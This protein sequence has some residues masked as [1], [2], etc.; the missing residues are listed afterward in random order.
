LAATSAL[1]SPSG[2]NDLDA[3]FNS[4][5]AA[6]V[7]EGSL[8]F[9]TSPPVKPLHHHQNTIRLSPDSLT[10]GW[11]AL[12]QCHDNLDAV[13]RAQITFR[14]GYIRE[15]RVT[16]SRLIGQAWIQGPTVQLREV[17]PGARLC[18]EA[19]TR[20]LKDMGNGYFN[21]F[22]GPYMR[23]FLD[24]YYPMQVSLS[25]EYP[26]DML[27]VIDVSPPEQTGFNVIQK[28]GRLS[29]STIFEGELRTLIQFERKSPS[30]LIGK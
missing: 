30:D 23:K 20:A 3:W 17:S 7:N 10:T 15:L 12:T 9:L 8:T 19:Q 28:P 11:T 2:Q 22:N 18:L 29:V 24:G 21:L 16:E 26:A 25:I 5:S 27:G 13:P 14:E 6:G 4:K 1:A